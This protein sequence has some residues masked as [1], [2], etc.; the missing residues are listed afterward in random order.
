MI[1]A[2]KRVMRI[3]V[4]GVAGWGILIGMVAFVIV[5]RDE[6][7]AAAREPMPAL[8]VGLPRR[9]LWAY[10]HFP[11]YRAPIP[12]LAYH[13]ISSQ[14]NYLT[15]TRKVFAE[16]MAALHAGGFHT[17]STA[18]YASYV[19]G[20][21][22]EL[23]SRPILITFDDGRLDSYRGADLVLARYHYQATMFVVAA[24]VTEHPGFALH[25]SELAGM[26]QSGRWDMQEH[27]GH[28][29]TRYPI[30]ATG[31]LGE[32]Y[33]YRRWIPGDHAKGHPESFVAYKRRVTADIEW[34]EAQ[35]RAHIPGYHPYAFAVPY[36]NYGQRATNDPRIPRF[37]LH[38]I[39]Q[40]FAVAVDG[41]YLDEGPDRPEEPKG[42]TPKNLTYRITMGPL[43]G[44]ETLDC[45]LHEYA[46]RSPMW[47][48]Y[49]CIQPG[50]VGHIPHD[51]EA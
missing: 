6:A 44:V 22:V 45:R 33:A 11:M 40:H 8:R 29:H 12:V 13:G 5:H 36:S 48:E 49:A 43:V 42:R 30:D 2:L 32:A 10:H 15:V 38:L 24:W 27:A 23:P 14:K 20:E 50:P 17:I 37:F 47:H 31:R 21:A 7:A 19:L 41:D 51:S 9:D 4:V 26:Q 16:Q 1:R 46:V 25:W 39:H 3:V 34:G 18:T 28:E 35:L